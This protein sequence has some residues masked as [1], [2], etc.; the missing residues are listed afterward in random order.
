MRE[1]SSSI[2][3]ATSALSSGTS[4]SNVRCSGSYENTGSRSSS[5]GSVQM[6]FCAWRLSARNAY[7]YA[8][9]LHDQGQAQKAREVLAA[10]LK[11]NAYDRDLLTVSALYALEAG[12]R[13]GARAHVKLLRELEPED[14]R[15]ARLAAQVEGR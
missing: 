12:D 10:A 3:Y 15:Y 5:G 13:D 11:R 2:T 9:A 1:R 14:P 4:R 8:V 6:P 7:V